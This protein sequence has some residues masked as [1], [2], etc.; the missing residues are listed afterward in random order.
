MGVLTAAFGS[1]AFA[2]AAGGWF[3]AGWWTIAVAC[4]VTALL[5]LVL[6]DRLVSERGFPADEDDLYVDPSGPFGWMGGSGLRL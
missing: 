3:V 4:A 2:T 1:G 6:A 5:L